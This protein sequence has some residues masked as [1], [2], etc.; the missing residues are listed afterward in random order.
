MLKKQNLLPK[1]VIEQEEKE[2]Q[3]LGISIFQLRYRKKLRE[4]KREFLKERRR[5]K[6]I[7]R[8]KQKAIEKKEKEREKNKEKKKL[9]EKK[10]KEKERIKK[11]KEKEREKK[12]LKAKTRSVGRPKKRG[13]KINYYKRRKKKREALERKNNPKKRLP[14]TYKIVSVRNGR[15]NGYIGKYTTVEKAYEAIDKLMEESKKVIFPVKMFHRDMVSDAKFEY[16][17]LERKKD[18]DD[19]PV[20]LKNDY[21]KNVEQ[22]TNSENWKIYDKIKYDVEETF[23]VF[24]YD[25]STDRKTFQWIYDNVLICKLKTQYDIIRVLLYKNKIIFKDDDNNMDIVFCKC[26]SD[27]IR[28]YTLLETFIKRD[29]IKQVFF[30]G[31]FNERGEK[32]RKL[33]Q[34][35]IDFT[36]WTIKRIQMPSTSEHMVNKKTKI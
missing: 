4:K 7:E 12:K 28:F 14:F 11:K 9:K 18:G 29:K 34:E 32:K 13:R 26:V 36:G 31:S 22:K 17:I 25:N 1:E 5:L 2:A 16:L 6:K 10:L 3:E 20:F 23:W 15:Q 24:G 21:G 19:E 30:L 8:D 35:L 27:A 33:E